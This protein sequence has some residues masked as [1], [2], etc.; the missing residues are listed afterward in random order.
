MCWLPVLFTV[1][2]TTLCFAWYIYYAQ[3]RIAREGAIYHVF[4]RLGRRRFAGLDRELRD[5]MKE[6]GLRAEDPFDQVV[7]R[8][9]VIDLASAELGA[10]IKSASD[11]LQRRLPI[12]GEELVEAFERGVQMGGTPVSH[13][14]ALLHTRV[15]DFD[16]SEL[17]LVR[18]RGGLQVDMDDDEMVRQAAVVP[19]RAVFFLVS[20]EA[21]PGRHLRILA[22]LAGRAESDDFV[23]EWQACRDE[24]ELKEILLRDDRFLSLTL[25][26]GTP[27]EALIGKALRELTMPPGSLVALI[28]RYGST[29]VPR[30]QTVLRE[31]DRLTIIGEPEGL[32]Q[33]EERYGAARRA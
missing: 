24:Q 15:P 32:N 11:L 19:I 17:V 7:A 10:V 1:G 14:A 22:H 31:G 18:C 27:G 5:L 12:G 9:F 28:R 29:I 20:G 13:G 4:E 3:P 8:A 25:E 26:V 33:L 21:D 2:I 6:K 30:G 23:S 16:R